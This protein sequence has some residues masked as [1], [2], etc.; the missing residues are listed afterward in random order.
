MNTN[1]TTP[2][3][4]KPLLTKAG[5]IILA[6]SLLLSIVCFVT[7]FLQIDRE[8]EPGY[9]PGGNNDSSY[10]DNN[11]NYTV[12]TL[13]LDNTKYLSYYS[14]E[15]LKLE[16]SSSSNYYIYFYTYNV[17]ILSITDNYGNS[18]SYYETYNDRSSSYDYCYYIN[19]ES[20]TTYT[21]TVEAGYSAPAVYLG[22]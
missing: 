12:L 3:T 10:N 18:A 1:A 22:T 15:T 17:E 20:Y 5:A 8:N 21:I 13:N 7:G 9:I 14:G 19:T 16:F 2:N 11:D 4:K 6:V